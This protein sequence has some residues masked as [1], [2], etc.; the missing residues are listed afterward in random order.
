[1]ASNAQE[2]DRERVEVVNHSLQV[3]IHLVYIENQYGDRE[4]RITSDLYTLPD[5]LPTFKENQE[6]Y[7]KRMEELSEKCSFKIFF[8]IS[9]K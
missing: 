1:M 3:W 6:A 4:K 7:L 8:I 2:S 9:I 5:T